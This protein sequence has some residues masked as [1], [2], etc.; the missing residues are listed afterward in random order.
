MFQYILNLILTF[1]TLKES[2]FGENTPICLYKLV[3]CIIEWRASTWF[4]ISVNPNKNRSSRDRIFHLQSSFFSFYSIKGRINEMS[5][6]RFHYNRQISISV[7]LSC[8]LRLYPLWS[9]G[10]IRFDSSVSV[11]CI[12]HFSLHRFQC[13]CDYVSAILC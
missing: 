1:F 5:F 6:V 3:S 10:C 4:S 9:F 2:L 8:L 7:V 12:S 11:N 13:F